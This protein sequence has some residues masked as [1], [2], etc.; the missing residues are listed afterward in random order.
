MNKN[1][2]EQIEK[3]LLQLVKQ[4]SVSTSKGE[5]KIAE[6]II[7]IISGFDYYKKHPDLL[8]LQPIPGSESCNVIAQFKGEREDN[9]NAVICIGHIDTVGAEDYGSLKEYAFN[10]E[11]LQSELLKI[12]DKLSMD[13][14]KDLDAGGFIFGRGVFDMKCGDAIYIALLEELSKH[15][16]DFSGNIVFAFVCDEENNSAGMINAVLEFDRLRKEY[17]FKAA[18][19]TDYSAG[20]FPG[21]ENNY[22]YVG[23]VGK[24]MP[25]FYIVGKETH[26]GEI[27]SGLDPNLI[28]AEIV[29]QLDL[30]PQYSDIADGEVSLPPAVLYMRDLKEAYSV[31]IPRNTL[32]YFNYATHCSNP[33]DVLEK[34]VVVA[35]DAM[36]AAIK[37]VS[38]RYDEFCSLRHL[39]GKTL[40]WKSRVLTFKQLL[41]E[42]SGELGEGFKAEYNLFVKSINADNSMDEREKAAAIIKY[43]HS[44]WTCKDPV[45]IV[46]FL[47]PYYPHVSPKGDEKS[48]ALL[49]AVKNVS[50]DAVVR[51]YYPFISDLSYASAP[52][53]QSSIDCLKDNMPGFGTIYDLPLKEM[54]NLNLPVVNIGPKGK[55]AHKFTER[56]EKSYSFTVVPDM[57]LTTINKLLEK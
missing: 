55:D 10:P 26:V 53:N 25:A 5:R 32:V 51:N 39:D 43:V 2:S 44:R 52:A 35:K 49:E 4:D 7:D 9:S 48:Q 3:Y 38:K 45:V 11:K 37:T 54:H 18:I 41:G 40:P 22:I 47:P 21:D 17:D 24:L 6:L 19:D 29:K 42:V 13:V 12:K 57:I 56:L 27:F 30:N 28:S 36:D 20:L 31:Q 8:T 46:S 23:A 16:E 15:P 50:N 14:Q 33:D 1:R 34:M